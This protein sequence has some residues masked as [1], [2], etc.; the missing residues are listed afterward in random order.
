[1]K[2]SDIEQRINAS[3]N[4]IKRFIEKNPK[5]HEK[6]N[7]VLHATDLGLKEYNENPNLTE[8]ESLSLIGQNINEIPT[9]PQTGFYG[10]QT[11][12]AVRICQRLF[13]IT[14]SGAVGPVT[15]AT[16]AQQYDYFIK[17]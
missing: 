12:N 11:E 8:D 13:G 5:Y 2:I 17:Q 4:T 6:I 14:E 10:E 15:W 3:Y 9:L 7:N 1:M 16:I